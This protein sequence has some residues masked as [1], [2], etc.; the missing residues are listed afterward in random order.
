M[1]GFGQGTGSGPGL[2]GGGTGGFGPGPGGPGSEVAQPKIQNAGEI[3]TRTAEVV[4]GMTN[5]VSKQIEVFAERIKPAKDGNDK[6]VLSRKALYEF[7]AEIIQELRQPLSVINSVM[8]AV[9]SGMMGQV[10]P[11]Q[12]NMLGLAGES[13]TRLDVLINKLAEL[14]GMPKG[15]TPDSKILGT[16]YGRKSGADNGIGATK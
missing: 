7:L 1:G 12:K 5:V 16:V 3:V 6:P 2:G 10:T 13:A 4:T 9:G 11:T 15:L 14:F 8:S